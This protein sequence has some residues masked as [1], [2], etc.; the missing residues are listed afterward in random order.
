MR[1]RSTYLMYSF[2][3]VLVFVVFGWS[4][5]EEKKKSEVILTHCRICHCW[6][7]RQLTK[8]TSAGKN[9]WRRKGLLF[10]LCNTFEKQSWSVSLEGLIRGQFGHNVLTS[11]TETGDE[12]DDVSGMLLNYLSVLICSVIFIICCVRVQTAEQMCSFSYCV[13]RL[14]F[15]LTSPSGG[16]TE[17]LQLH[18]SFLFLC[19]SSHHFLLA[20]WESERMLMMMMMMKRKGLKQSLAVFALLLASACCILPPSKEDLTGEFMDEFVQ[21]SFN[22]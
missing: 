1:G 9:V 20:I 15:Q 21:F 3:F 16:E 18:F 17:S 14:L 6:I 5:R 12:D 2:L 7:N 19:R 8:H 13:A 10:L 11:T 4:E 22:K